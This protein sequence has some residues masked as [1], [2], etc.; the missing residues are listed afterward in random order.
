MMRLSLNAAFAIAAIVG[1][2]ALAEQ[3]SPK[4][5]MSQSERTIDYSAAVPD[6]F[7][8]WTLVPSIKLVVPVEPD[9][10]ANKIYSQMVGRAYSDREGNI[11]MLLMAYG[12]RQSDALQLHRP[13]LCYVASGFRVLPPTTT[14][15]QLGDAVLPIELRR[16]VA[17]REG[18]VER[19]SYWMRIG[20]DIVSN[21]IDRQVTKLRYGLQ[22]LIPDGVL[23]RVST[24]NV[25]EAAAE[26]LHGK[27]LKDLIRNVDGNNLKYFVGN[28]QVRHDR[29][30]HG[31]APTAPVD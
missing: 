5:V 25:D 9:S 18:R 21:L 1:S 26:K 20:N 23:I 16:M 22:G 3:M 13:E 19:I 6:T 24:V 12:P 4:V 11:V 7:G 27:F 14:Q 28:N 2:A 17:L 10:L 29:I 31:T 15:I 8:D 30:A